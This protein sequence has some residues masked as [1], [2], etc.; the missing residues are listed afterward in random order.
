MKQLKTEIIAL[1]DYALIDRDNKLS[2]LGIF[3]ELRVQKF[4]GGFFDKFFVAT[5]HGEAGSYKLVL[6]LKRNGV[7]KNLLNPTVIDANLE[8]SGKHNIIVRL[9]NVGFEKEGLYNFSLHNGGEEIG[10]VSLNVINKAKD[11]L[12]ETKMIN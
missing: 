5:I 3:D 10:A 6:E 11:N 7:N 4:P 1:C 8:S 2:I 9:T 12:E